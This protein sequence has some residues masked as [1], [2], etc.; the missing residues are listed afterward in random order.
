MRV[1]KLG[2]TAFGPFPRTQE[3]DFTRLG[4]HPLFLINGPTGSGKTTILDAI[5][6]ALYGETTGTEREGREMRCDHAD[7]AHE[8]CV[9]LEFELGAQRYRILR[10]P[11]QERPKQRGE[12]TTKRAAEAQLFQVDVDGEETVLVPRKT[13][14]ANS[15]PRPAG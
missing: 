4:S 13:S 7:T 11:E 8:A 2:M 6:F 10:T 15:R 12:G 3:I 9:E 1:T 14:D 5:C